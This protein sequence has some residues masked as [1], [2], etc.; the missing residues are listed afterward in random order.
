[1]M[2]CIW[3][4]V[5]LNCCWEMEYLTSV[6]VKLMVWN[7]ALLYF[8]NSCF[9]R[10]FRALDTLKDAAMSK[11]VFAQVS[12]PSRS[13]L[14]DMLMLIAFD[15]TNVFPS[16]WHPHTS[17]AL[18]QCQN[19]KRWT[20]WCYLGNKGKTRWG[21]QQ[22]EWKQAWHGWEILV[23]IWLAEAKVTCRAGRYIDLFHVP[24]R[25]LKLRP[26]SVIC[27]LN[28]LSHQPVIGSGVSLLSLSWCSQHAAHSPPL[29]K[30]PAH[31]R[32][33]YQ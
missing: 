25:E 9:C 31:M 20:H 1:M 16:W 4:L 12:L 33:L 27:P 29:Q 15:S 23:V 11:K 21:Y 2:R 7:L 14:C 3:N 28:V 5:R 6:T 10:R 8:D 30:T 32:V 19:L 17:Y 22:S 26:L 13:L 18:R 24:Y